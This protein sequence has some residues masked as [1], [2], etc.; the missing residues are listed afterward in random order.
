[1]PQREYPS[2]PLAA[3]GGV[4]FNK[5]DQ[6]LLIRRNHPPGAGL[7]SLPGGVV[8]LGE[9]LEQA[10][11]RE[12]SEETGIRVRV[13]PVAHVASRIIRNP[14][15]RVQYHYIL[16]DY[17]CYPLSGRAVAGSDASEIGWFTIDRV[18]SLNRTRNLEDV[19][20]KARKLR[21]PPL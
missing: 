2:T 20:R 21:Q 19:I 1:V 7:W 8:H 11:I 18:T 16:L 15:N 4:L 6:V 9:E 10:L 3:V 13:G 5:Q 14:E 17:L 12:I